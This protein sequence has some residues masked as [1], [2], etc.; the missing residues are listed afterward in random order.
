MTMPNERTRAIIETRMFLRGLVSPG[1]LPRLPPVT[2]AV[3]EEARALL[4]HYPGAAHIHIAHRA[5]PQYF[6]PMLSPKG[7]GGGGTELYS[8]WGFQTGLLS[9][10]EDGYGISAELGGMNIWYWARDRKSV[11]N[12]FRRACRR[13]VLRRF[14]PW[15][16]PPPAV[17]DTTLAC[18]VD[19]VTHPSERTRALSDC[20]Q[21]LERLSRQRSEPDVPAPV[22]EYACWL[23]RHYPSGFE[24]ELAHHALPQL[25]GPVP[26]RGN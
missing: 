19:A 5:V 13:A 4:R 10:C 20:K 21:F 24:F 8:L 17:L 15:I 1:V 16:A 2:S 23:L 3:R 11:R 6:G 26:G 22:R 18:S 7:I 25:F 14:L 12:A 9:P